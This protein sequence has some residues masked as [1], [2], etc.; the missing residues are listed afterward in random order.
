MEIYEVIFSS[1]ELKTVEDYVS[2]PGSPAYGFIRREEEFLKVVNSQGKTNREAILDRYKIEGS[3]EFYAKK[4]AKKLRLKPGTRLAIPVQEVDRV[5]LLT[6]GIEVVSNDI[7]AFKARMLAELES[8]EGYNPVRKTALDQKESKGVLMESYPEVTVWVWCRALSAAGLGEDNEGQIV[9]ITPFV[10]KVTTNVGKNGGNF[11]ISLPPIACEYDDVQSKWIITKQSIEHFNASSTNGSQ[12]SHGFVAST[13]LLTEDS[14][15]N[16]RRSQFL[17]HNI[18]SANDLVY[19]RYETLD[20]EK[21]QRIRDSEDFIIDRSELPG[22]VYDMIGLIDENVQVV[23]GEHAEVSI[24]IN[25]R[26]LSKLFIDDGTYFYALEMTQ[27][28]LNFAGGSTQQNDL[29]QRVFSDNALQY[30][31]L[32]FNNSIENVLKFVI[33]QLS[34]IRVVPDK[35]FEYYGDRRNKKFNPERKYLQQNEEIANSL[36]AL[37]KTSLN[38][39]S[40]L[41]KNARIV[42]SSEI[43]EQQ[44]LEK[45]WIN[46]N[47]FFK[48]IRN[49][50]VRVVANNIT[51]GWRKFR[52][53]VEEIEEN[54]YPSSF[55][56][57]LYLRS[58]YKQSSTSRIEEE[59]LFTAVDKYLDLEKTNPS[60]KDLWQEEVAPG[61]WSIIK[62]VIDDG[63]TGRRIVDS[64]ASSANGS[65]LNFIR[66]ICQEPFVEFYM[67]TYG[68][69]YH[70]IVRKPPTNKAGYESL[71]KKEIRV[72]DE[73]G[74][75]KVLQPAIIDIEVEDVLDEQL[76]YND[77]DAISWYHLTPQANFI[78]SASTYSLAYLPA[79]FFKEYAEVWGSR[80]MQIAHNYMPR[81]P[82]NS[83][84]TN[85]DISEEQAYSDIKYMIESNAY[86]PFTRKGQ[87]KTNGDRR[88]K[89]GNLVRY[90]PTGEIF[91]IDD[92][93]QHFQ[94]TESGIE[95]MTTINVSRGMIENLIEG[96]S[97]NPK[98]DKEGEPI[99]VSYFNIVN[100]DFPDFDSLKRTVK[101][102]ITEQV[103]VGTEKINVS[104]GEAYRN[105]QNL[106]KISY[107]GKVKN[108]GMSE[109]NRYSTYAKARF[110]DLINKINMSGYSVT[111]T[112]G[113]RTFAEQARLKRQN[114]KNAAAGT[115]RHE[116]GLAI[117]INIRNIST[118]QVY[119]KRSN[120]QQWL[121]T[122]IPQLGKSLGFIWGGD[123]FAN[124]WD[125]IHFELPNQGSSNS[126]SASSS[127]SFS[128]DR[129][130]YETRTR[131]ISRVEIDR[132]KVF[133]NFQVNVP[134]FNYFLRR[135]QNA[136]Q[137][138]GEKKSVKIEEVIL[139]PQYKK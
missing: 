139:K 104:A 50:K 127:T 37:K 14:Q 53:G 5:G 17:F 39:I 55:G 41:R 79:I 87:I 111:V 83:K 128:E 72:E 21:D 15:G 34:T 22:R 1:P 48:E 13:N 102:T 47:A 108:I 60:H 45:I 42:N 51:L 126:S 62:L 112:S 18:L 109:L 117:D 24:N 7:P 9:N 16:V 65:L 80:P 61:I 29:M 46:V 35:L 28:Q 10:T 4:P 20:L 81:L 85:L 101:D 71:L 31:G 129:P 131:H 122:G 44:E 64:S 27:G 119:L 99:H 77:Q 89:R 25:G 36:A 97:F 52:Y 68:D 33:Q 107:T 2:E 59:N 103:Q 136:I 43:A 86:M 30:F 84:N 114:S 115:S 32:Y 12:Q 8:K 73:N 138:L 75:E 98:N 57:D 6:Q 135:R 120:R 3:R 100:T 90:K 40:S 56:R 137:V 58:S 63:V 124:Y 26:D 67:D 95:R 106:P 88:L 92:V 96:I 110:L 19:I 132:T 121:S 133:A 78:G 118:G 116:R 76:S 82:L 23:S 74:L 94:I 123:A 134:Q 70:L 54:Q 113:V 93:Q 105:Q 125:P 69:M 66:K 11:Q 49:K 91:M 130:I 38:A